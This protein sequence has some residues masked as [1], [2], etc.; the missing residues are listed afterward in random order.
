MREKMLKR[1]YESKFS[2]RYHKFYNDEILF[3]KN[4]LSIGLSHNDPKDLELIYL[5]VNVNNNLSIEVKE[6]IRRLI[7]AL[8]KDLTND[9]E[10]LES[11]GSV[12]SILRK[13]VY[14]TQKITF[15]PQQSFI[16]RQVEN[17]NLILIAGTGFGKTRLSLELL[18]K[19]YL[20]FSGKHLLIVP[21]DLLEEQLNSKAQKLFPEANICNDITKCDIVIATPEKIFE[22]YKKF[23]SKIISLVID[24]AHTIFY[25]DERSKFEEFLINKIIDECPISKSLFI[26]PFINDAQVNELQAKFSSL[27]LKFMQIKSN[28]KNYKIFKQTEKKS[29]DLENS[30]FGE[31]HLNK[32]QQT[33]ITL[34]YFSSKKDVREKAI[35]YQNRSESQIDFEKE[36]A[37]WSKEKV[38]RFKQLSTNYLYKDYLG[39]NIV[40]KG[41]AYLH[42]DLPT[43]VKL[44]I[45]EMIENG[46]IKNV[47]ATN[48]VLSGIDLPI[49]NIIIEK[50]RIG[51]KNMNVSD[52]LNLCGRSGR[53][54]NDDRYTSKGFVFVKDSEVNNAW[55]SKNWEKL[56]DG[57]NQV[58]THSD[59][60]ELVLFVNESM[61]K[62]NETQDKRFLIDPRIN[63]DGIEKISSTSRVVVDNLME[64]VLISTDKKKITEQIDLL[65]KLYEFHQYKSKFIKDENEYGDFVKKA[66]YNYFKYNMNIDNYLRTIHNFPNY[67]NMSEIQKADFLEEQNFRIKTYGKFYF[68]MFLS[69]LST[70]VPGGLTI[71]NAFYYET[72]NNQ[73]VEKFESNEKLAELWL[74]HICKSEVFKKRNGIIIEFNKKELQDVCQIIAKK[75][76]RKK[77]S[78]QASEII[79]IICK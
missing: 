17:S 70:L 63:P 34:N 14:I 25:D 73:L 15:T 77:I 28:S 5:L 2:N 6:N 58:L 7:N 16:W 11:F 35:E 74:T 33:G 22:G 57:E 60:D 59:E 12:I 4:N 41:V 55:W 71:S 44:K 40:L 1:L 47:F 29:V 42:S 67:K 48:S 27:D 13:T 66:I 8:N 54:T 69:H 61:K 49:K 19:R 76:S 68:M 43:P 38:E 64:T 31:I 9:T 62:F 10:K 50:T 32:V 20:K 45:I 56:N 24:E 79:E 21:T 26:S 75:I 65:L 72:L 78:N 53:F 39:E 23:K 3:L 51:S 30:E 36:I 37:G 46:M 18:H 52:F